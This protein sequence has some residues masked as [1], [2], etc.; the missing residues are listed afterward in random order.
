MTGT[1]R[2]VITADGCAVEV[3]LL[4]PPLGEA[5]L[6]ASAVPAGATVLD[7]GCG[8]GRIAHGLIERGFRVVGVDQSAEML[9]H[10]RGFETVHA[11][12]AGL[13]L[14]RQFDA[15]LLASNLMNIPDDADRQAVLA[16]AVRHLAPGGRVVAQ[17]EPA[18]WFDTAADG[19]GGTAGRVRIELADVHPDGDL[20]SAT[21]RY[22]VGDEL[23]TQT[24]TSRR[25]DDEALR[26][27][28]R[29][30]GLSFESWLRDDH[31][32]F[33]ATRVD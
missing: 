17:W 25:F 29:G 23:W 11:P 12:I 28:L 22:W 2:G 32:W 19:V 27:E 1:G 16:T 30:A 5:E 33:I 15:V 31:T 10:A 4:M 21:V 13:E 14:D 7:L 18:E 8:V 20:L 3:Y 6:V 9:A 26:R 24:F